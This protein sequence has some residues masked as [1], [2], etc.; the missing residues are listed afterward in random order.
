MRFERYLIMEKKKKQKT[1]VEKIRKPTAPPSERHG[2]SK[3][4]RKEKHKKTY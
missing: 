1:P 4:N 3:Y 2:D